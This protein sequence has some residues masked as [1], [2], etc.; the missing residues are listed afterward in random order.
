MKKRKE[1]I[2]IGMDILKDKHSESADDVSQRLS[3]VT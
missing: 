2:E 3:R 1:I